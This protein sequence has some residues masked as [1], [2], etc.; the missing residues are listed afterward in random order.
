MALV[1]REI[2]LDILKHMSEANPRHKGWGFIRRPLDSFSLEH[3]LARHLTLVFE[4]LR[5]PPWIYRKRFIGDVIPSDLLKILLQMVLHGL[6]YLHS[7]CHVIHT[8][9]SLVLG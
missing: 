1:K 2:E 7:E 4:P 8:G 5:E 3:G 9:L 6:D